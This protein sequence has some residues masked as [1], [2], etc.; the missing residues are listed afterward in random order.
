MRKLI[1]ILAI[2]VAIAVLYRAEARA[3]PPQTAGAGPVQSGGNQSR[4]RPAGIRHDR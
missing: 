4:G 1:L 3:A 2:S